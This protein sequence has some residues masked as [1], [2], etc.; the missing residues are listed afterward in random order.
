MAILFYFFFLRSTHTFHQQ[1]PSQ[2]Q[3]THMPPTKPNPI[4]KSTTL[5]PSPCPE[6]WLWTLA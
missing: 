3:Y 4:F 6:H 2:Q 5:T 1:L